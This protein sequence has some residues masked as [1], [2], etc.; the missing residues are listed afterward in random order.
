MTQVMNPNIYRSNTIHPNSQCVLGDIRIIFFRENTVPHP[1]VSLKNIFFPNTLT[2][3]CLKNIYNPYNVDKTAIL[4]IYSSHMLVKCPITVAF[5][6]KK[7]LLV[8]CN[9]FS[10]KKQANVILQNMKGLKC[11]KTN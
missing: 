10:S 8:M 2:P 1:Q 9:H 11:L 4:Q 7:M 3:S 5:S 6:S